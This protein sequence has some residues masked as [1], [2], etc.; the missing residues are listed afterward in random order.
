MSDEPYLVLHKDSPE[1]VEELEGRDDMTLDEYGCDDR[2]R[3]PVSR[4]GRH[5]IEPLL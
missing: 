2:G 3:G 5:L 4:T 1:A